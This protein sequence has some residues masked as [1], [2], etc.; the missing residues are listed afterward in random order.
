MP[1][2]TSQ[3]TLVQ[4]AAPP[5]PPGRLAIVLADA[6]FSIHSPALFSSLSTANSSA[7]FA[8][9]RDALIR[10]LIAHGIDPLRAAMFV[11]RAAL[12]IQAS[13]QTVLSYRTDTS[14]TL[15]MECAHG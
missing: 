8:N 15:A 9:R 10:V 5:I 11:H 14:T 3:P 1:R 2:Y 12:R 13:L 7:E 6:R 4:Q